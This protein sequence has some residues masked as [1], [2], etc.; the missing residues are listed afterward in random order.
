M[1]PAKKLSM[2][3]GFGP[4]H[5]RDLVYFRRAKA[6]PGWSVQSDPT[7]EWRPGTP[8]RRL[9]KPALRHEIEGYASHTSV[10]RGT[11]IGYPYSQQHFSYSIVIYRMGLGMG[12][13]G[14]RLVHGPVT[15]QGVSQPMPPV[16]LKRDSSNV[17]GRSLLS[18]SGARLIRR[19][20]SAG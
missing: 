12:V 6:E 1:N 13:R 4:T 7:R 19:N 2:S 16:I 15:R 3:Y 10:D 5:G 9:T 14:A 11:R 8:D 18:L 20:G 17:V